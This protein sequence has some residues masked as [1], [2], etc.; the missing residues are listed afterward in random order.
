MS[1]D[2]SDNAE[3]QEVKEAARK[4]VEQ[5]GD[6]RNEVRDLTLKLLSHGQLDVKKIKQVVSAVMEGASLGAESKSTQV[7]D[8]LSDSMAGIDEA[9]A[10]SAEASKLAVEEAAS[11]LKDFGKQ[12]LKRAL[13]DL[14]TLED[15]FLDIIKNVAKESSEV[16][17]GTLNDLVLHARNS[18]TAVG[19]S[20]TN[21]VETL[22]RE[23]GQTLRETVTAGTDAALKVGTHLS[24]AAA[25][26]LEGIA[27][28]LE[29]KVAS[30]SR[31]EKR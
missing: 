7:K 21:V 26:F 18:G 5:G 30:R 6:I 27:E 1:K 28:T 31:D 23:L 2:Q 17:G 15:M 22:N 11:H 13:D 29:A 19:K 9:L 3:T 14:V 20:S 8:T 24:Q 10:K 25:G 4:V 16:V 12:D